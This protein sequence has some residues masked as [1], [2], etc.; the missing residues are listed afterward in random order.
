MALRWR[1]FVVTK[2]RTIPLRLSFIDQRSRIMEMK[3]NSKLIVK[4]RKEKGW[5]QQQLSLVSGVSLRTIQRV[6]N[7]GNTSI[8][9]LK[10]LASAF[11]LDFNALIVKS[12][13]SNKVLKSTTASFAL[14]FSLVMSIFLTSSTTASTG[15]EIQAEKLTISKD[16]K[17]TTFMGNVFMTIPSDIPFEISTIENHSSEGYQLK[18]TTDES[19]FLT[20]DAHIISSDT[21]LEVRAAE[22][23]ASD[24][25]EL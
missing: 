17:E 21:G 1:V 22:V 16:K 9:T 13:K 24:A 7:E 4:L 10:S 15:I 12:P 18:I 20:S 25:K 2:M 5:S 3:I 14:L 11:E 8:E 23:R 6:E 19:S